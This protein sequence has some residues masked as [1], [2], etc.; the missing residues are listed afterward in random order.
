[1]IEDN[2]M[3]NALLLARYSNTREAPGIGKALEIESAYKAAAVNW[4]KCKARG[5]QIEGKDPVKTLLATTNF[6]GRQ[7][8]HQCGF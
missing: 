3:R 7:T 6:S 5:A 4:D 1:M 2:T 8:C